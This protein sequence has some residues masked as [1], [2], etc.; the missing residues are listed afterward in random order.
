M[1]ALNSSKI[2]AQKIL[3]KEEAENRVMEYA[4]REF[5]E[6][7]SE[8]AVEFVKFQSGNENPT[9]K[10]DRVVSI[11]TGIAEIEK[12]TL[13]ERVE[14]EALERLKG[15][16]EDA[17]KQG[18]DLGRDEGRES[19]YRETVEDLGARLSRVDS[20]VGTLE[21]L[22]L[23]MIKQ[24]EIS[25]VKLIFQIASKI[26]MTEIQEKPELVLNVIQQA[27]AGSLDEEQI[28]IRLAASDL[29]F[30]ESTKKDLGQEFQF[31]KRAKLEASAEIEPGGCLVLTNFGQ[32]DATLKKRFEKVWSE[33]QQKIPA[34]SEAI[35]D[36]TPEDGSE[37]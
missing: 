7:F 17:Y 34:P 16:Q 1:N 35:V 29:E 12:V 21:D 8:A 30:I 20:V 28:T 14:T 36:T 6:R 18:Y 26:A 27:V 25:F 31:M 32:I 22:K 3:S 37:S 4:P 23:E 10:I 15:L 24:N 11:T 33:I 19:A 9:F 5:P 13:S 2:G